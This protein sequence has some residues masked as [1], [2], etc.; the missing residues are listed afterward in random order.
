M[1]L[2]D[3][4]SDPPDSKVRGIPQAYNP[5]CGWDPIVFENVNLGEDIS[6]IR[7]RQRISEIENLASEDMTNKSLALPYPEWLQKELRKMCGVRTQFVLSVGRSSLVGILDA[8]RTQIL[9]WALELES[10]GVL[11]MGLAFGEVEIASAQSISIHANT[12]HGATDC[13]K[14][15]EFHSDIN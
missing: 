15:P 11:G 13:T 12:I 6:N 9:N 10:K 4:T 8:V 7:S 3:Y 14:Q 2:M 5:L 1:S